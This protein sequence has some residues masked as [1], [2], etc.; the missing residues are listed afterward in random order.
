M[1]L[2]V[3]L[4]AVPLAG[5]GGPDAAPSA[6]ATS[7]SPAPSVDAAV[8]W[9]GGVCSASTALQESVR[10]MTGAVQ[11]DSTSSSTSLDQAKAQV[12]DLLEV[13]VVGGVPCF[14]GREFAADVRQLARV[15]E[16]PAALGTLV[17]RACPHAGQVLGGISADRTRD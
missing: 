15:E 3:L 17:D 12:D 11:T 1:L 10:Q 6:T 16:D 9:A 13:R 4:S 14:L 8:S 2:A 7:A 5:C